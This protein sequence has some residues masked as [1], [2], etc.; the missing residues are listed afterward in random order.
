ME[1]VH[2]G[3]WPAF[4]DGAAVTRALWP[5]VWSEHRGHQFALVDTADE[6]VA[7]GNAIPSRW[8][9]DPAQL[10]AGWDDALAQALARDQAEPADTLLILTGVVAP[11]HQGR[12]LA[13]CVLEAFKALAR[14]HGLARAVV[15]VRPTGKA[16][17]PD[18]GFADW[19]DARRPDGSAADPWLRVHQR[20][21]GKA[22]RVEPRSQRAVGSIAQ[23]EAWT[24][25]AFTRSGEHH[26]PGALAPVHIDLARGVGE[27]DEPSIWYE[28]F[29]E[30]YRGPAWRPIDRAALRAHLAEALPDYMVPDA[31]CFVPALPR[32]ASG[33]IDEQRLPPPP[34]GVGRTPP[35]GTPLQIALAALV[36]D[37]LGISGDI[38]IG[39]DFFALGGQSLRA[40]QLLAR[41]RRELGPTIALK[42]FYREPTIQALE[43]LVAE[44][45]I[46]RAA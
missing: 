9:G 5:R 44:T 37:V 1:A 15:P 45:A 42:A 3:S 21:G 41:I 19:C 7:T 4:F 25:M 2:L 32:G 18:L 27:Y 39:D 11:S 31:F 23:W 24:G 33:K 16:D 34:D 28:H 14:G 13:A 35:P 17:R 29:V 30:P 12:G 36:R 10:P 38:G 40:I 43:R 26:V 6:V 46:A 8:N 20:A 22:L